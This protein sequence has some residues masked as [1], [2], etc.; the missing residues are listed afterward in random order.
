[1]MRCFA[2]SAKMERKQAMRWKRPIARVC[3]LA[4]ISTAV[5]SRITPLA[6]A[7]DK[8]VHSVAELDDALHDRTFAGRVI[9]PKDSIWHMERCDKERDEF[10]NFICAPVLEL[11]LYSGVTLMGERG[12]LGSRPLLFTTLVDKASS[13]ALFEVC[14]NDVRVESLHLRGPQTGENHGIKLPYFHGILVFEAAGRKAASPCAADN[15]AETPAPFLGPLG[16]NVVIADNELEQWT[17]GAVST[18][19]VHGNIPLKE[20]TPHTCEG[21]SLCCGDPDG[22][23]EPSPDDDIC[24]KPLTF[25]DAGLVRVERNFMHHNARDNGG[26]GVDVNGGSFVTITGNVFNYNRHAVTATGRGHSGY[27]A[28]FN[29]VLQGGYRQNAGI[30]T[31]GYYNQ[32]MDVHGEESGG[33]GGAAGTQFDVSLNTFRGEQEYYQ[34]KTRSAFWQRGVPAI[35]IDFRDNVLVHNSLN[36]AVTFKGFSTGTLPPSSPVAQQIAKFHPSGN[37]FDTDAVRDLAAGDFDGDG[38]AD[39]FIANGTAWFYS[40]GG[41]RPWEFLHAS[42]K[43]LKELGF[44]DIDNDGVTDVLYR[45]PQG[46]VGY[47]KS[48]RADL[49]PLTTSP[50]PMKDMRSGDFDGDGKT[51]LFFTHQGQWQIW[52]GATKAWTLG[53]TSGKPIT[54]LLFGEF[55][56]VRG[57]DV[58]TVLSNGWVVSTAGTSNWNFLNMRLASTFSRAIAADFDGNGLTDIAFRR[59]G[60]WNFSP[61]GRGPPRLLGMPDIAREGGVVGRFD[62]SSPRAMMIYN[63]PNILGLNRFKIWRG[64]GTTVDFRD[65]SDHDMR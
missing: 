18:R 6:F 1:M 50:V 22:T 16:R 35:G 60:R 24:W 42:T 44:A 20:W 3:L 10:G 45:D 38:V 14:G 54:D 51:D 64:N 26:Y 52:R 19:G 59:L 5:S 2:Q 12:E 25:A 21:N 39:I 41:K 37:R 15:T 47:L 29:Y 65:W 55:D 31:D 56:R 49:V 33:Y 48:G 23:F 53:N 30:V 43:G 9:I 27:A 34:I 8:T 62:K 17:G 46:N 7:A 58:A 11:P 13:R 40:R 63:P 61:D 57:T 32:H 36:K 4:A 28:R